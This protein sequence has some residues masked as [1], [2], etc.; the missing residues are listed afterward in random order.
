M[1]SFIVAAAEGFRTDWFFRRL[2]LTIAVFGGVA[3]AVALFRFFAF[4]PDDGR[5]TGLGQLHLQVPAA[6]IFGVALLCT[7]Y[8]VFEAPSLRWRGIGRV[9]CAVPLVG[10]ALDGLPQRPGWPCPSPASST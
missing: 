7:L 1:V 2:T 8:W 4:P 9:E 5:L 3:A 10:R 6:L